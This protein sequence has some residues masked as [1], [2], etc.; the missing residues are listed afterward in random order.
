MT[1]VEPIT[2]DAGYKRAEARAGELM[3]NWADEAE[4]AELKALAEAITNYAETHFEFYQVHVDAADHIEFML[5]QGMVTLDELVP[6]FGGMEPFIEFMTRKRNLDE[7]T[8]DALSVKFD[9]DREWIDK[10][11]IKPSGWQDITLENSTCCDEDPC[12]MGIGE[13]RERLLA[14]REEF[15]RIHRIGQDKGAGV[16]PA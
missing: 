1:K 16:T 2:D 14:Y 5:D 13:W 15:T 9:I 4:L 11:F 3:N 6:V 7:M 12:P 10:E 8:L